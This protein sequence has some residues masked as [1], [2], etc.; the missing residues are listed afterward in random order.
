MVGTKTEQDGS[1]MSDI[2]HRGANPATIDF[3]ITRPW[4]LMLPP[5]YRYLPRQYVDSFFETGALQLSSFAKF[6]KHA[7]EARGDVEEGKSMVS[8]QGGGRQFSAFVTTGHQ[9]Y[10]L[11]ASVVLDRAVMTAFSG[12]DAA[13]EITNIPDFAQA[14]ARQLKGFVSG[15]SGHCIYAG[16][17]LVRHTDSDPF[18]L[19]A[20]PKEGIPLDR[21]FAATAEASKH[22]DLFLKHRRYAYQAEYRLIWNVDHAPPAGSIIISSTEARQ[23]CRRV[24]D[25]EVQ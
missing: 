12:C 10:V 1:Y 18:P 23:F 7:D 16:R 25:E 13:I 11:S 6:H 24:S 4:R 3:Q 2:A 17:I 14:V 9:A 19:P 8:S 21:M 20:D 15:I 5:V 22:E